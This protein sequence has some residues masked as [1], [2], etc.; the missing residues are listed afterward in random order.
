M[1]RDFIITEVKGFNLDVSENCTNP[2][3]VDLL[4]IKYQY[5]LELTFGCHR[6]FDCVCPACA[7]KW[8]NKNFEK[9]RKGII[10]MKYPRF[11]TL[12]VQYDKEKDDEE[13][14]LDLWKYRKYLF[15]Q[16]KRWGYKINSWIAVIEFPNHM[17]I[18]YDGSYISRT[19][20]QQLWVQI[21][22]GSWSVDIRPVQGGTPKK[23]AGY[24]SKYM[25]KVMSF[26]PAQLELYKHF[27]MVMT[28][29][30]QLEKVKMLI[31]SFGIDDIGDWGW[32]RTSYYTRMLA[33]DKFIK[34]HPPTT[35]A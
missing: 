5:P 21:T 30:L 19:H 15:K 12:A 32:T 23:M 26:T 34:E 2:F 20:I 17:H 27:K 8:R 24:L 25:S 22:G 33:E 28:N 13:K 18:V 29:N 14:V 16:L 11:L 35:T 6:R 10:N 4:D 1:G 3:T 9:F 31:R 7:K